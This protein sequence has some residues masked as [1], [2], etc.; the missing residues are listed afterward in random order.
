MTKGEFVGENFGI[1]G[2]LAYVYVSNERKSLYVLHVFEILLWEQD[3]FVF[4]VFAK[5]FYIVS[6]ASQVERQRATC[7]VFSFRHMYVTFLYS[8][9]MRRVFYFPC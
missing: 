1:S 7:I 8:G 9:G 3:G 4:L 5:I 6:S 2:R